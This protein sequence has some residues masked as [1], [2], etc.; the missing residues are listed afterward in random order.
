MDETRLHTTDDL[1]DTV[2]G[3]PIPEVELQVQK[4][5]RNKITLYKHIM[6][7]LCGILEGTALFDLQKK[8][9][10]E[11]F[12]LL[13]K[14]PEEKARDLLKDKHIKVRTDSA[15][16]LFLRDMLARGEPAGM[17]HRKFMV[18]SETRVSETAMQFTSGSSLD[19]LERTLIWRLKH[20][21]CANLRIG[22]DAVDAMNADELKRL[23]MLLDTYKNALI[24]IG[25]PDIL[26][27]IAERIQLLTSAEPEKSAAGGAENAMAGPVL[28]DAGVTHLEMV[29][30]IV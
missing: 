1:V 15:M 13:Q 22:R 6:E 17:H 18:H 28:H 14:L 11:A 27:R 3:L 20:E 4:N 7:H 23:N 25:P 10:A 21:E 16:K 30:S 24:R 5:V 12:E 19:A 9:D 29:K 2:D 8:L 26:Y